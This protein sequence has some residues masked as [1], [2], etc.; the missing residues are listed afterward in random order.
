MRFTQADMDQYL[1]EQ[2]QQEDIVPVPVSLAEEE[3]EEEIEESE[4][5]EGSQWAVRE[6]PNR[7]PIRQVLAGER[8]S[9][10]Y[11]SLCL[12]VC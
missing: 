6:G 4:A 12:A 9:V 3:E 5:P 2:D 1:R 8:R 10:E 11:G 7:M